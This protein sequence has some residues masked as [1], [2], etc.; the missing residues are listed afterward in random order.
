MMMAERRD[1]ID[2]HTEHAPTSRVNTAPNDVYMDTIGRL[3]DADW[4]PL[5]RVHV[6]SK[7]VA[8][9]GR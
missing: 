5:R 9:H 8:I 3:Q 1:D 4:A 7:S 2:D 6:G